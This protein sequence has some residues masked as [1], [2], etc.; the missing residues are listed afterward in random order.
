M[1]AGIFH[2]PVFACSD[3]NFFDESDFGLISDYLRT[4]QAGKRGIPTLIYLIIHPDIF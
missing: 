3:E 4:D 1:Q 2:P